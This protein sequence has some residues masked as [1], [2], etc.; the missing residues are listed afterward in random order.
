MPDLV[1]GI[2]TYD[3]D[4]GNFP[5]FPLINMFAEQVPTETQTVLQSRPGLENT[6]TSMGV[7]PVKALLQIDGILSGQLFGISDN[8]LYAGST[9][10]GSI[11]GTGPARLAG[12]ESMIFATQGL[13]LYRYNGTTL[14]TVATPDSFSVLDLCV[15]A[16]RL[17]VINKDTGKFYWSDVLSD[18]IA[19]LS[20]ATAEK[21]PDK[22][23]AC[24]YLGD[25]LILFGSETVEFWP[26]TT[27]AA[28]PFQPLIGRVFP[29]GIRDTGCVSTFGNTFAWVTNK[30]QVCVENPDNVISL[31][32]LNAKIEAST[33]VSLWSFWL[34]GIEFLALRLDTATFVYCSKSQTWSEFT[35]YGQTNWIPRCYGGTSFGS[36]IDGNLIRW[37]SVHTDFGSHLER[38]FRAGM[39]ID[40]GT[41]H[42]TNVTLRVN[43]GQS[44]YLTGDYADPTVEL[45]VSK[46]G[47]FNFD[48]W[49]DRS[50]GINGK[51]RALV[52]WHSLGFYSNPGFFAEVRVVDPVPFRVSRMTVNEPYGNI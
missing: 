29:V 31:P 34:E 26:S 45:R 47:G 16:S 14:A 38:R 15:G 24:L 52:Q 10:L 7:G 50:L 39:P 37:A 25:V 5:Y 32:D 42:I 19:A 30:N 12:F 44:P 9:N 18:T 35:S 48:N 51:Y 27:D 8:K 23:K 3:R 13:G 2:S 43:P 6:G 22:L 46:D 1:Y 33:S 28:N 4:R 41:Q 36:G 20:F 21:S 49:R 11:N 17:I 40:N